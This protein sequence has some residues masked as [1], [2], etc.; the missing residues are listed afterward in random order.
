MNNE[1]DLHLLLKFA[2]KEHFL[3]MET[4]EE[5]T[6]KEIIGRVFNWIWLAVER[7][8]AQLRVF[9]TTRNKALLTADICGVSK[10]TVY[11]SRTS[12]D[13]LNEVRGRPQILF[14]DYDDV[15]LSRLILSFYKRTPPSLP[16]LDQIYVEALGLPDFPQV[17]KTTL[18]RRMKK[19]GFAFKKRNT[20]MQ[21]YQRLDVVAQ[22]H[23]VLRKLIEYRELG[24]EV[25]CKDE[26]WVN[27]NHTRQYIWQKFDD[28][29]DDVDDLIGHTEWRGGFKV[30]CGAG[31]RLIINNIGSKNG[32]LEGAGECFV[33]QKNSSDYHQEM[34]SV[35]FENWW[36]EKVLPKLPNMSVVIIDNAKYHSRL[37]EDSK[38]PTT[39]WKKK[40]IQ[41][42]LK[43][44]GKVFHEKDTKPMLLT[45]CKEIMIPKR[46]ALEAKTEKYCNENNKQ[47][48]ILR[49]PIGHSE[50]NVE[51][52]WAK[53]KN[54][55]AKENTTFNLTSV[56]LLSERALQS[57]TPETWKKA[58]HHTE[59]VEAVFRKND[60][61]DDERVPQVEKMIID[62]SSDTDS[63]LESDSDLD[64][65]SD[66]D[67]D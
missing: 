22:R 23:Y 48:D 20:K 47:L 53:V 44:K 40:E 58:I 16:T 4:S 64:S 34:N 46:Y 25:F 43:I 24:F 57:V 42:W 66:N 54:K 56:K 6:S 1:K 9:P 5:K 38:K 12:I 39:A 13:E 19:L 7:E 8:K 31:K 28:T 36:V 10:S 50:L 49:L 33:G 67:L 2:K 51:L 14:D 37:T 29:D 59:K 52:I 32:F 55:V 27:T 26:T 21:V 15:G 61:I 62:L 30:P 11:R 45:I 17:S 41:D 65:C 18:F 63:D 60:F 35:H 3:S